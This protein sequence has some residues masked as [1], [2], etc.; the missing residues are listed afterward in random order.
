MPLTST[1]RP[2]TPHTMHVLN[3]S[4]DPDANQ[5]RQSAAAAWKDFSARVTRVVPFSVIQQDTREKA[6]AKGNSVPR[7]FDI[8][9]I[10][11]VDEVDGA[12]RPRGAYFKLG[13]SFY[14]LFGT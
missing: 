2:F 12:E 5:R 11:A 8:H 1:V 9:D 6:L 13:E 3:N 10:Q 14:H 7:I 4:P